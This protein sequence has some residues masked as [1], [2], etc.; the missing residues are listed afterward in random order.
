MSPF[1]DVR[2]SELQFLL[3]VKA[4]SPYVVQSDHEEAA[5]Y[6]LSLALFKEMVELLLLEGHLDIPALRKE[7]DYARCDTPNY[8]PRDLHTHRDAHPVTHLRG[9]LESGSHQARLPFAG[10]RRIEALREQLQRDRILEPFGVLLDVRYRDP[11]LQR[12]LARPGTPVGAIALDLDGFKYVNDTYGHKA[13]DAVLKKY[14]EAV[15]N[16]V[17]HHGVALRAGGDEVSVIT[18]H[19]DHQQVQSLCD[20]IRMRIEKMVVEFEGRTLPP[21]TASIGFAVTP[22][23]PRN[24]ALYDAADLA[25]QTAKQT[26]KNRVCSDS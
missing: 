20:R 19:Y 26:G 14:L 17:A 15:R 1:E 9:R 22:P 8:V 12:A 4:G 3:A 21:V 13:G 24:R 16:E 11:E 5:R 18:T 23:A 6:G 10:L 2:V 7:V 25:Q